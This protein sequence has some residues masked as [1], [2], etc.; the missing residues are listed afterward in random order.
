MCD[1]VRTICCNPSELV[2]INQTDIGLITKVGQVISEEKTRMMISKNVSRSVKSTILHMYKF[3]ETQEFE[4]YLGVS[5][6]WRSIRR[7]DWQMSN[8]W[9]PEWILQKV[10]TLLPPKTVMVRM[11]LRLSICI[12]SLFIWMTNTLKKR[13]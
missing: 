10:Q 8:Q 11:E 7:N 5:L 13:K 9:L 4:K 1:L 3:H 6:K 2:N 12:T